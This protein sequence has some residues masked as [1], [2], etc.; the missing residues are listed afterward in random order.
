MAFKVKL[1]DRAVSDL[2]DIYRDKNAESSPPASE[3]DE[4][5]WWNRPAE[6]DKAACCPPMRF[7]LVIC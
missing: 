7:D 5:K 2:A 4:Q 3:M 6:V 1:A